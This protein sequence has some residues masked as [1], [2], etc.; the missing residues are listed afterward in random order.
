MNY[1]LYG[2]RNNPNPPYPTLSLRLTGYVSYISLHTHTHTG[3]DTHFNTH[4]HTHTHLSYSHSV[5]QLS[6]G[7]QGLR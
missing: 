2:L 7:F 1:F 5:T 6:I 4:T 3:T